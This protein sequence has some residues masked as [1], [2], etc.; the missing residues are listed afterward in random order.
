MVQFDSTSS[1]VRTTTPPTT[2]TLKP[3]SLFVSNRLFRCG[4][5][6]SI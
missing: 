1:G 3:L 4:T 2:S 5:W 6:H